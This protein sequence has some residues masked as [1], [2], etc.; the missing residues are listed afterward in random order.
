MQTIPH[1]IRACI[2][3][4]L[5]L[6]AT[7]L[8]ADTISFTGNLPNGSNGDPDP[9]GV[10]L[11]NFSLTD[12]GNIIIQT[13]GYGG[14]TNAAATTLTGTG[15]QAGFLSG[16]GLYNASGI[17]VLDSISNTGGC[18]DTGPGSANP[19]SGF[20]CGDLYLNFFDT[21]GAN[22]AAGDYQLALFALGNAPTASLSDLQGSLLAGAFDRLDG[23]TGTDFYAVDVSSDGFGPGV[24]PVPEPPT[25]MLLTAGLLLPAF[26]ACRRKVGQ[27]RTA[28]AGVIGKI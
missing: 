14:G 19:D 1:C 6:A 9:N 4:L 5:C 15:L 12:P 27:A 21:F 26:R 20:A 7:P 17:L 23:Q 13:F 16:F 24:T 18:S 25:L 28:I 11:L 22:A 2:L 3:F 8:F 10:V